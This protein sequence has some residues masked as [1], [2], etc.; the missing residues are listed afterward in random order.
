MAAGV[1]VEVMEALIG[2]KAD[3]GVQDRGAPYKRLLISF[4]L[5]VKCGPLNNSNI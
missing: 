4:F 2:L 3:C 1:D 5:V